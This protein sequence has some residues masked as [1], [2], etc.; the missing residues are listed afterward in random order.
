MR[1]AILLAS[2][3]CLLSAASAMASV[4]T[5]GL[6]YDGKPD[7][8]Q[9]N[10]VA[11]AVDVDNS[12]THNVGDLIISLVKWNTNNSASKDFGPTT[13]AFTVYEVSGTASSPGNIGGKPTLGFTLTNAVVDAANQGVLQTTFGASFTFTIGDSVIADLLPTQSA[14]NGGF[15][16]QTVG[17]IFSDTN[18]P[19]LTLGTLGS[20]LTSLANTSAWTLDASYGIVKSTDFIQSALVDENGDG[21]I[22]YASEYTAL[23]G[24][25]A[26]TGSDAG[27]F[28][29]IINNVGPLIPVSF[30]DLYTNPQS[31]DVGLLPSTQLVAGVQEEVDNGWAFADNAFAK[32]NPT[33]E[34]ASVVVWSVLA[35]VVGFCSWRRR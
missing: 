8:I 23:T 32:L 9:D 20:A 28:S 29:V 24:T 33:P 17:A 16:G 14:A 12:G 26:Q 6:S 3:L 19:N 35:I 10:S 15:S 7:Q 27:G 5:S 11:F 25:G 34:P 13:M 30:V 31:A 1:R 22:T 18:G 21:K 4:F 2:A